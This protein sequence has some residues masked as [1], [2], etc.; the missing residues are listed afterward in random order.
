MQSL[1]KSIYR[2]RARTLYQ[3]IA[4]YIRSNEKILDMGGGSGY[5]GELISRKAKVTLLDTVDYNQSHLPLLL[6]D[7]KRIQ[8]SDNSFDTT[9]IVAVLHHTLYP[10]RLI[11]EAKRVSKRIVIV[12]DTY[13]TILGLIFLDAWDW[14]WNKTSGISSFYNFRTPDGWKEIFRDLKLKLVHNAQITNSLG[15]Y[16]INIF[17]LE[18]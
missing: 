8:I 15:I 10:E 1:T 7:G 11:A 2:Y 14:F 4:R 5:L 6:F 12:E 18:K 9:I 16:K 17:I 13:K 3:K